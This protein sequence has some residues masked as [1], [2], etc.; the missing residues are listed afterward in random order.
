MTMVDSVDEGRPLGKQLSH[1]KQRGSL[2]CQDDGNTRFEDGFVNAWKAAGEWYL[3]LDDSRDCG[4][5]SLAVCPCPGSKL[6]GDPSEGI[7]GV[8][9]RVMVVTTVDVV[10][11]NWRRTSQACHKWRRSCAKARSN[12]NPRG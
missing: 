6:E 2:I 3:G 5:D 8:A 1:Q 7:V 4:I 11:L 10:Q 9:R 12:E